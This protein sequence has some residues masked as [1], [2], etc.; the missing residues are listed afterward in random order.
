MS[1]MSNEEFV[2]AWVKAVKDEIGLKQF[3]LDNKIGYTDASQRASALRAKGVKLPTMPAKGQNNRI[4]KINVEELNK[5][6]VSE[7][8]EDALNWRNR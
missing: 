8:G 2:R 6:V 7:L 1:E 3:A 4:L 5:I